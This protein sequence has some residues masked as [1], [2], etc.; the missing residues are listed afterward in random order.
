MDIWLDKLPGCNPIT[1]NANTALTGMIG[2]CD[3]QTGVITLADGSIFDPTKTYPQVIK[4]S[5]SS[6]TAASASDPAT[7]AADAGSNG[8]SSTGSNDLASTAVIDGTS[9]G[10]SVISASSTSA[11][12]RRLIN[13]KRRHLHG[14]ENLRGTHI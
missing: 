14:S 11:R 7:D 3:P 8:G 10:A 13:I 4:A 6:S 2:E 5:T 9:A 12:F 1:T